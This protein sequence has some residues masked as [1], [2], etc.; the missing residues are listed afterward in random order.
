MK[1]LTAFFFGMMFFQTWIHTA[2]AAPV[3]AS[4]FNSFSIPLLNSAGILVTLCGI[5]LFANYISR[6]IEKKILLVVAAFIS[7]LGTL[8]L[9][10]TY[11]ASDISLWQQV[12][13]T[14][15]TASG[16]G[17][18]LTLWGH[19][20]AQLE[21]STASHT[22]TLGAMA[23]SL[24]LYLLASSLPDTVSLVVVIIFPLACVICLWL[25]F[26]A[27]KESKCDVVE[28][29]VSITVTSHG[30]KTLG[31]LFVFIFTFS[32]P[33][34]FLN[35][36]LRLDSRTSSQDDWTLIYSTSLLVIAF[37]ILIELLLRKRN[38]T[39][40]PLF[41]I[42][43]STIDLLMF[44]FFKTD[45][46]TLRILMT[47]GGCLFVAVF[48]SYLGDSAAL[49]RHNSFK[50]FAFGNVVN[51][52]GLITGWG[53]GLI[54]HLYLSTWVAGLAVAMVYVIFFV[55]LVVLPMSR[56]NFFC[57]TA[58][59]ARQRSSESNILNSLQQQ[60]E[61]IAKRYALSNREEEILNFLIRGRNIKSIATEMSL[62]MN[63]IKTHVSHIYGKLNAHSR[64]ELMRHIEETFE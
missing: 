43:L 12:V 34:N 51:T 39:V 1:K 8:L 27:P 47:S 30:N 13:G 36:F 9:G 58:E 32:I 10:T 16:T 63:T 21:N 61:N 3:F 31:R 11:L 25:V 2:A 26:N 6:I 24:L 37:I 53:L 57:A 52:F 7:T 50:L 33:L 19:G 64:E 23:G 42:I 28:G 4:E 45:T 55:G 18:L 56:N 40:L 46:L 54:T 60:C 44:F 41:I 17:I 14:L 20:Y 49:S 35:M 62:S 38:I 59:I 5:A 15:C 22:V 29:K 48:Y